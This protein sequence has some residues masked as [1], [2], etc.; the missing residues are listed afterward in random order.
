MD[1]VLIANEV[2]NEKRYLGEEG[3]VFKINFEKAYDV[4][5][6]FLDHVLKRKGFNTKWRS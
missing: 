4:N 6:G 1:G 2:V 3:L 5:Q